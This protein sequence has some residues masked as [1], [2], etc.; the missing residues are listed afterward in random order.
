MG[1]R[2]PLTSTLTL[3]VLPALRKFQ[4]QRKTAEPIIGRTKNA[5]D[6]FGRLLP[7]HLKRLTQQPC[8]Q[9]TASVVPSPALK[10]PGFSPCALYQGTTSVVPSP[11]LKFPGFS[12]WAL[13]QGTTSV[14]PSP[15]L[16]FP[17]LSPCALYQGTTSVV[18][19]PA[20]KFPGF[21]PCALYQGTTSVKIIH[22][23]KVIAEVSNE[24]T[25]A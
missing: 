13:Y 3:A 14:V 2:Q 10:F 8:N 11:A 25:A 9:G 18:P 5:Q 23:T 4:V 22:L 16:K 19:S 21:S 7:A 1:K 20:L 24:D 12:P 6:I 15:A 17:G